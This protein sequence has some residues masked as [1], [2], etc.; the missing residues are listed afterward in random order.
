[1]KLQHKEDPRDFMTQNKSVVKRKGKENQS[2]DGIELVETTTTEDLPKP[3]K[4]IKILLLGTSGSGKTTLGRQIRMLYGDPFGQQE[5]LHFKHMIRATCLEDFSNILVE[6]MAL[7][8]PTSEWTRD[9]VFFLKK[10]RTRLV[11]RCLMDLSMSLWK[12]IGVQKYLSELNLKMKLT[13]NKENTT[14]VHWTDSPEEKTTRY[15]SD[16]PGYHF[17]PRLDK[18][19]SHGY[20]PTLTEILSIRMTTTGKLTTQFH[21]S[22]P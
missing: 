15:Q 5:M 17:L 11:D 16:D 8:T 2:F 14:S 3:E 19:M 1:M 12:D 20:Q 6:Y 13:S 4:L 7:R 21:L 22:I 10:M 9:C 18:I